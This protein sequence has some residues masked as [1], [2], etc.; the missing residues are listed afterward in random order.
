M[1][2]LNLLLAKF[3]IQI[4]QKENHMLNSCAIDNKVSG[5]SYRDVTLRGKLYGI[6]PEMLFELK[7]LIKS[8]E[9]RLEGSMLSI[10]YTH[11]LLKFH[12]CASDFSDCRDEIQEFQLIP[13]PQVS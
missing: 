5:V 8:R 12:T 3:L 6:A 7:S 9:S 2:S 11:N 1:L 13:G 4:K 10:T